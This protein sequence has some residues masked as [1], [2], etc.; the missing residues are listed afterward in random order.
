MEPVSAPEKDGSDRLLTVPEVA[1]ALRVDENTV[2][3]WLRRGRLSGVNLG[4]RIGYRVRQ[5]E[6]DRFL[7]ALSTRQRT[8]G[9]ET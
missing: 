8:S 9:A 4:H 2:R 7:E 6:L 5:S 1:A 3:R